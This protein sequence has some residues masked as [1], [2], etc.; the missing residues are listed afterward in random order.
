MPIEQAR[1]KGKWT[2]R[3]G[4]LGS[5]VFL[6]LLPLSAFVGLLEATGSVRLPR[7]VV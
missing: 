7:W 1:E 4:L 5:L 3:L 2:V 6:P